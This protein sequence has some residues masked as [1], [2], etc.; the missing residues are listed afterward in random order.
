MTHPFLQNSVVASRP[1]PIGSPAVG[2]A[3]L[4][5]SIGLPGS[6]DAVRDYADQVNA[7]IDGLS[8]E[9]QKAFVSDESP[10]DLEADA[11]KLDK[12]SFPGMATLA[13]AKRA[14]AS[15][16]RAAQVGKTPQQIADTQAFLASWRSFEGSWSKFYESIQ[17][18][19]LTG[20][21]PASAWDQVESYETH[22]ASF[23]TTF[24]QVAG[25]APVTPAPPTA[26][27]VADRHN[28]PTSPSIAQT[29]ADTVST[30]IKLAG[31]VLL[32]AIVVTA[33][34]ESRR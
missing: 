13:S 15:A 8:A 16:I 33:I 12:S 6:R 20:P 32:G 3:P 17:G 9:I 10:D 4:S 11:A 28:D 25:K 18:F 14:M 27:E 2:E 23:R 21:S 31:A 29:A 5:V 24:A 7:S 22:L 1:S 19:S 30:V 34:R 26:K